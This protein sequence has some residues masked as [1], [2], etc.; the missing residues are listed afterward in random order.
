MLSVT[1][2][3]RQFAIQNVQKHTF[4]QSISPLVKRGIRSNKLE[5]KF[6][7]A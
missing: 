2:I 7:H 1:A 4:H 5:I 3:K 6:A